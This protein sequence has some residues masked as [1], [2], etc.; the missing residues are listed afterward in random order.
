[1]IVLTWAKM[2]A[3]VGPR[4]ELLKMIVSKQQLLLQ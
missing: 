3:G 1:V 2:A 4:E